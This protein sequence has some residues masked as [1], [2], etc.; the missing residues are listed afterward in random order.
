MS[1]VRVEKRDHPYVQIDKRCLED[2]RLSWKSKGILAYLLSRPDDWTVMFE[3]LKK[4]STDGKSAIRSAF[5]E[6]VEFGYCERQILQ[7]IDDEGKS[8][9]MGSEYVIYEVPQRRDPESLEIEKPRQ[10][11]NRNLKESNTT[12]N[13]LLTNNEYLSSNKH[14]TK[15]VVDFDTLE[16]VISI[17]NSLHGTSIR[18]T[19]NKLRQL[20]SRMKTFTLEEIEE[21]VRNRSRS[22]WIRGEG[23]SHASN[24][25]SLFRND[26]QI[27]KY[28]NMK[29]KKEPEKAKPNYGYNMPREY[30]T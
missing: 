8:V 11:E 19:A 4:V 23:A 30:W 10:P 24:W 15:E 7:K 28:L 25:D 22:E 17:W 20:R 12:N 21:A 9:L 29:T 14:K 27:D 16:E 6:L 3:Q 5:K 13:E 2:T 26:D 1:I 18:P